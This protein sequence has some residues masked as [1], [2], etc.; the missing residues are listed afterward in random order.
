MTNADTQD[1]TPPMTQQTGSFSP[2]ETSSPPPPT[3]NHTP[4]RQMQLF[5][6]MA[7]FVLLAGMGIVILLMKNT[8]DTRS[9]ATLTGTTLALSPA[10]KTGSIGETFSV[11]I[12]MNTDTDTVSA[13]ELHL[14]YDPTAIQILSFTAGTPLP[15]VLVPETHNNGTIAVTLGVQ[16]T[17]PFKG[18]GIV[19]TWTV[20]ILAAK[21]SSVSFT[22]ATQVAVLG[23]NTNALTTKTGSTITGTVAG[24]PTPTPLSSPTPTPTYSPTPTLIPTPTST[25]EPTSTPTPTSVPDTTPT[26]TPMDDSI[27]T[28]TSTP[29]PNPTISQAPSENQP[30][31]ATTTKTTFGS[32]SSNTPQSDL[33]ETNQTTNDYSPIP[34]NAPDTEVPKLTIFDQIFS[35]I[36]QFFQKLFQK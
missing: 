35:A 26:P 29:T 36:V 21:Q 34:M 16:P 15:V 23:K 4:P 19:G 33:G 17:S 9:R 27:P 2:N 22:S 14:S 10:T 18:A 25:P 13:A 31:P 20:K 3:H 1:S 6:L 32:L 7:A 28:D 11:G 12:T 8:Q 30:N 5:S 24:T